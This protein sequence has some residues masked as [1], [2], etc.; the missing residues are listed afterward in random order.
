MLHF[1]T[2]GESHG[3]AL[4]TILEGMVAGV[5][6]SDKEIKVELQRRRHG[7]GRGTRMKF[8]E[9]R[10]DI[11]GGV[12]HGRTIG[13]PVAMVIHNTEW[14]KWQQIMAVG[15]DEAVVE[16]PPLSRPRPGHADLPGMMKYGFDDARNILERASARETAARVA[17]G[18]VCKSF[19]RALGIEVLSHVVSIGH[20]AS[21]EERLP[22]P[23]DLETI[24]ASAL[25]CL[26]ADAE[27]QMVA[28]IEDMRRNGDT[29]GG[30]F[31]VLAYGVPTGLGSHVHWER[32]IDASI[33]Q[34]LMS[35]QAV[36]G[37]EI[38]PGFDVAAAPGSRA[39]D[40][41]AW[42]DDEGFTRP[43]DRSGGSEGGITTGQVLRA[44]AA[45]KP[46]SSLAR[47]LPTI[48]V[49]TKEPAPA[50]TQRSDVCAVPAAG[51]VGEAMVAFVLARAVLEKFGGDSLEETSRNL[52][53]YRAA[54]A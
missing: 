29:L 6:V 11:L 10:L 7:Y 42:T 28:L 34:A 18:A 35:I 25:R 48:D 27:Q 47:S 14:P 9:D 24:D 2:A 8:E 15:E 43:T 53:A 3:P 40:E 16:D 17:V 5:P 36:K 46:L 1:L 45:M 30:V 37:V 49:R 4:V 23:A 22:T 52:E 51:V 32:R 44:R 39:H 19:L 33:A 26:D 54:T 31:E 21:S 50:I 13:S 20:I 41:I 12:R 38:G